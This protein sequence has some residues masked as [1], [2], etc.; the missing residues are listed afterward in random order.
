MDIPFL[1]NLRQRY[2]LGSATDAVPIHRNSHGVLH[3][4]SRLLNRF[5]N[6]WLQ[7]T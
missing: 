1:K 5:P 7:Q 2:L 4:L 3:V 6:F